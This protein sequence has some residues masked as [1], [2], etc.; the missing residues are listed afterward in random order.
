MEKKERAVKYVAATGVAGATSYLL[1]K[2]NLAPYVMPAAIS[3]FGKNRWQKAGLVVAGTA[4]SRLCMR[5]NIKSIPGL[6]LFAGTTNYLNG[7]G[8]SIIE[9]HRRLLIAECEQEAS[10]HLYSQ[11]GWTF[12]REEL[13]A[14]TNYILKEKQARKNAAMNDPAFMA[15]AE[16]AAKNPEIQKRLAENKKSIAYDIVM[17]LAKQY[18]KDEKEVLWVLS[19]SR[20]LGEQE[21]Q[22]KQQE[23]KVPEDFIKSKEEEEK[24]LINIWDKYKVHPYIEQLMEQ[25]G[26]Q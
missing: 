14:T 17:H 25:G 9:L 3:T 6:L 4:I 18:Q 10:L 5:N 24:I 7:V 22:L 21:Q 19:R 13:R 2:K 8:N 12:N 16:E 11:K 15:M 23:I 20:N 26:T 1:T